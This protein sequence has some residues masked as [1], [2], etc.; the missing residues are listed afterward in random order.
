MY[1]QLFLASAAIAGIVCLFVC[2]TPTRPEVVRYHRIGTED[3]ID[4]ASGEE[5]D[6]E[7]EK[8]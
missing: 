2:V 5:D 3:V 8:V 7:F 4:S 6:E 1:L